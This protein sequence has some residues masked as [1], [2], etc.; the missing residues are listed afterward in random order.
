MKEEL[1]TRFM[2]MRRQTR[3]EIMAEL[4]EAGAIKPECVEEFKREMAE[5]YQAEN[6]A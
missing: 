6:A 4:L 5:A 2:G 3:S 1:R